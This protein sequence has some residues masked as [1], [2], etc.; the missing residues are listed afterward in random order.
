MSARRR[1]DRRTV[2]S[3]RRIT[4]SSPARSGP[5]GRPWAPARSVR[6][7]RHHRERGRWAQINQ[8]GLVRKCRGADGCLKAAAAGSGAADHRSARWRQRAPPHITADLRRRV[9]GAGADA[10]D[11]LET[12]T[13]SARAWPS[14]TSTPPPR[15]AGTVADVRTLA[16]DSSTWSCALWPTASFAWAGAHDGCGHVLHGPPR[17]GPNRQHLLTSSRRR[18][19]LAARLRGTRTPVPPRSRRPPGVQHSG[20]HQRVAVASDQVS[21]EEAAEQTALRRG[22]RDRP[23]RWGLRRA[24]RRNGGRHPGADRLRR[25]AWPPGSRPRPRSSSPMTATCSSRSAAAP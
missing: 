22:L 12:A 11:G 19:Q 20:G 3:N 14:R 1:R 24:V 8:T 17:I 7:G 15:G 16:I 6:R 25:P 2:R 18:R 4:S 5:P 10:A 9:G 13:R 21:N 23:A